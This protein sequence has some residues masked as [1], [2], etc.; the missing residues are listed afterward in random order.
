MRSTK[1]VGKAITYLAIICSSQV[2]ARFNFF[3]SAI[4][5]VARNGHIWA[6]YIKKTKKCAHSH[7]LET[8]R[9]SVFL[10]FL[11]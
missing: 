5:R 1:L 9:V 4:P 11:P 3:A 8:V 7:I 2:G 6:S 10:M